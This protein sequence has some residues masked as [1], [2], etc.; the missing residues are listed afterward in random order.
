MPKRLSNTA[1]RLSP[2]LAEVQRVSV[3]VTEVQTET[4]APIDYGDSINVEAEALSVATYRA[5][6]VSGAE[7]L[8]KVSTDGYVGV[9][10]M[11]AGDGSTVGTPNAASLWQRSA[12]VVR[13]N[14]AEAIALVD[15]S[16]AKMI[17]GSAGLIEIGWDTYEREFTTAVGLPGGSIVTARGELGI[18]VGAPGAWLH[19]AGRDNQVLIEHPDSGAMGISVDAQ[20]VGHVNAPAGQLR[21]YGVTTGDTLNAD[22]LNVAHL[23]TAVTV[24]DKTALMIGGQVWADSGTFL[25]Q[26]VSGVDGAADITLVVAERIAEEG[27]VLFD[28]GDTV[29]VFWI[30]RVDGYDQERRMTGTVTYAGRDAS[31]AP[32]RQSYTFT[33]ADWN[34]DDTPPWESVT[35]PARAVV[36]KDKKAQ[37]SM[38]NGLARVELPGTSLGWLQ[39]PETYQGGSLASNTGLYSRSTRGALVLTE[40]HGA[41]SIGATDDMGTPG[42][43]GAYMHYQSGGPYEVFS[44]SLGENG[45]HRIAGEWVTGAVPSVLAINASTLQVDGVDVTLSSVVP[46]TA[47][48]AGQIL[49]GNAGGTAYAPVSMSGDAT[50]ASTGALTIAANAV[51]LGK[52]AQMATASLIGRNT[53]GTGNVEVLSAATAKTLLSLNNVENTALSTW[54]GSSSITTVGTLSQPLGVGATALSYSGLYVYRGVTDPAATQYGQRTLLS[55]SSTTADSSLLIGHSL[56]VLTSGAGSHSGTSYGLYASAAHAAATVGGQQIG[57]AAEAGITVSGGSA[58]TVMSLQL[59]NTGNAGA[60]ITTR[61]GMSVSAL[62]GSTVNTNLY[63]IAVQAQTAVQGSYKMGLYVGNISGGSIANYAIYTNTGTVLL[64]DNTGI[65]TYPSARLHVAGTTV[66]YFDRSANPANFIGRRVNGSIAS[67]TQVLSGETIA[68]FSAIGYGAASFPSAAGARIQAIATENQT[69]SA[70][71]MYWSLGTVA[72]GGT[73][74]AERLRIDSAGLTLPDAHDVSLGTSTG[75]KVGTSVSQKLGLWGATPVV[76]PASANQA[77]VSATAATQ[78]TPWGF[79]TQAQADGIITLLNELRAALVSIGAIKG[80]A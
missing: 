46:N 66:M 68:S 77:A 6:L 72:T 21:L 52:M 62:D 26:E 14:G 42:D 20:G 11:G 13:G 41:L 71:G 75:T 78:T 38:L 32:A 49:V 30:D 19:V 34:A 69:T 17:R 74:Y 70:T 80:S 57:I 48:S 31:Y 5:D 2:W 47:P 29:V 43:I 15:E 1:D 35:L 4:P 23:H 24:T 18:G 55:K 65:G 64:G 76:Q 37:F 7:K 22:A 27:R 16:S 59:A 9:R 53:A 40:D 54:A 3:A 36:Y 61:Y 25:M 45:G 51:S 50:L 33:P 28:D 63:C 60:T 12:L 10:R 8:L 73:T 39:Y 79:S 44:L 56:S 58:A 67:P